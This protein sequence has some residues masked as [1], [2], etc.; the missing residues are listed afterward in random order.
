MHANSNYFVYYLPADIFFDKLHLE[1]NSPGNEC[2]I[3]FFFSLMSLWHKNQNE[4]WIIG[5]KSNSLIT[6]LIKQVSFE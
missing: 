3:L 6:T 5:L 2:V 4:D 1:I